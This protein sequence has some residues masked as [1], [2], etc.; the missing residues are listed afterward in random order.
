MEMPTKTDVL[1]HPKYIT[2][3]GHVFFGTKAFAFIELTHWKESRRLTAL[4][5]FVSLIGR[6]IPAI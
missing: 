3:N 2:N 1:V 6:C 4:P 5:E